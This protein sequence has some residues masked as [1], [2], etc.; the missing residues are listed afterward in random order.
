MRFSDGNI[1]SVSFTESD[2][3]SVTYDIA[4]QQVADYKMNVKDRAGTGTESCKVMIRRDTG[5]GV[6]VVLVSAVDDTVKEIKLQ[7][8]SGDSNERIDWDRKKPKVKFG[9]EEDYLSSWGY[10]VDFE[11]P[12]F[13]FAGTEL[14]LRSLFHDQES[15]VIRMRDGGR[16]VLMRS[17][18]GSS[19]DGTMKTMKWKW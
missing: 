1:A 6:D 4:R 10:H 18:A 19:I 13:G 15:P 16:P 7:I 17:F 8:W 3:G 2:F 9:G 14:K 5:T 12:G 11:E